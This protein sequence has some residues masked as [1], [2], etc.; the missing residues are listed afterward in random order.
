MQPL[1]LY[2]IDTEKSPLKHKTR[3]G[4]AAI[5]YG[6]YTEIILLERPSGDDKRPG[7]R[8]GLSCII[9]RYYFLSKNFF[10]ISV[11]SA[12]SGVPTASQDLRM[13]SRTSPSFMSSAV[14]LILAG[15]IRQPLR[16]RSG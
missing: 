7:A 11:F 16:K 5:F 3:P 9:Q 12:K 2:G 4:A 13:I 8:P 14:L 6:I 1:S 10:R 15:P